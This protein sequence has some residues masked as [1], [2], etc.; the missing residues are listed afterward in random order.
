MRFDRAKYIAVVFVIFGGMMFLGC[1]DKSKKRAPRPQKA[2]K[3]KEGDHNKYPDMIYIPAGEFIMG[4]NP[5]KEAEYAASLGFIN[6]P[7]ENEMPQRTI[8]LDGF[9]IDKYEVTIGDYAKY[10]EATDT[11][12]P[13]PLEGINLEKYKS[14]PVSCITWEEASD[15]AKWSHKSIPTEA[16]WEKAARGTDGRRYPWG[17]K[18][19]NLKANFSKK[20]LFPVGTNKD[21]IS[22]YGVHDMGGSLDEW[23]SNWYLPYPGG[24]RR[25]SEYGLTSKVYRGGSWGGRTGHLEL[26]DYFSRVAYRGYEEPDVVSNLRGFRCV[27]SD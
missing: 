18:F 26:F 8:Y 24:K 20:G 13:D 1:G 12:L 3:K 4:T 25:D 5:A 15:Y 14:Y 2:I 19:D 7:Y 6:D 22:P 9:Y 23:V 21:D 11:P 16:Q 27:R 10:A 17:N